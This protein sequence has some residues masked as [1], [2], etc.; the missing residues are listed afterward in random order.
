MPFFAV[1]SRRNLCYENETVAVGLQTGT[2]LRAEYWTEPG[3]LNGQL[4]CH[5]WCNSK[6]D[7]PLELPTL[8]TEADFINQLV[9][10]FIFIVN[11]Q[12]CCC[13]RKLINE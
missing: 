10:L 2:I 7:L 8:N 12:L 5:F 13:C 3:G 11:F 4:A 6:G 9:T 1:A